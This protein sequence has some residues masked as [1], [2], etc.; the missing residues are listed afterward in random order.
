[1]ASQVRDH[2]VGEKPHAAPDESHDDGGSRTSSSHDGDG[3][4]ADATRA[5]VAKDESLPVQRTQ[6]RDRASRISEDLRRTTSNVLARVASRMTTRTWPEPPP[7]PDGGLNAWTQVAMGWLVIFTTW[8]WVNSFG[9][10]QAYYTTVLPQSPSTVSW[11]GSVQ[12]WFCLIISVFSGRL[13]DAGLF[14]PTF[15]VGAVIQVVGMFLMSISTQYWS[16]MLT[17]GVLTGIGS[18]IF[19]TPSLALVATYFSKRR[20]FA[21][22]LATTGNSAGGMIYPVVVRQLLPTLGFAWTARVLAFINLACLSV[23]FTFMRPRL[24]PRKSGPIIDFTAF[25]ELV[26]NG[27]TVGIFATSMSNYFT[28]YYIASYGREILGLPY[29][30]ASV[31]VILINGAGIVFRVIPPLIADRIGPINVVTPVTLC[32]AVVAFSWL[33]VDSI[34]GLYVFTCFYGVMSGSFQCLTP[35]TVA[36]ITDRLDMV[37]TRLGMVFSISSFASLTGP[38]IGG[39]IQAAHAGQFK[40]AQAWAACMTLIGFVSFVVARVSKAG[41]TLKVRC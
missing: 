21:V 20:G 30:E 14:L 33:A 8:G 18:G 34:P 12:I 19:F 1:M 28:F 36:S 5:G 27:V 4:D 38:P 26:Y 15:L 40:H 41:L 25:R 11:I 13:L 29:S 37:G 17:Q 39:A 32:W 35:T 16:L 22:G 24:P 23:V 7:P 31:M 3:A 2:E 10:F 9:S 6:T